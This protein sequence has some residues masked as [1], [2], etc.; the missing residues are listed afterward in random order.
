MANLTEIINLV[1]CSLAATYGTGSKGCKSFFREVSSIWLTKRGFVFDG[2]Q[3][4]DEEYVQSVQAAGNLIV[5]NGITA[6]TDNSEE[7]VTETYDDGTEQLV[8][9]GKYK[10]LVEFVNGLYFQTALSSINSQDIFDVSLIDTSNNI[11][12]T[13]A[14]NGS[15]KGFSAGMIQASKYTFAT[16][17]VGSKQG[18]N[19]QLIEPDELDNDSSFVSGSSLA[20]YKPKSADGINEVVLAYSTAPANSATSLVVK[21]TI[22]QG[23]GAFIGGLIGNF[24]LKVDG[25][26]ETPSALSESAGTYTLTV[27]SKST[28]EVLTLDLYDV[29]GAK[30]VIE[31]DNALYQSQTLTATVV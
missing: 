5:L 13:V 7:M 16:G 21:A 18:L 27:A 20:P 9:K 25:V 19:I 11:L 4:L 30:S 8:R 29:S 3:A 14:A 17:A 23:G 28:N 6:F 24:L 1:D 10:F 12:G 22:K 31:L 26:T 2:S 15:L